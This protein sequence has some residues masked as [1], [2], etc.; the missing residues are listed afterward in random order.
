MSA[1]AA[2]PL[3]ELIDPVLWRAYA[4]TRS[5]AAR[6]KIVER[7]MEFVRIRACRLHERLPKEVDLQDLIQWGSEGLM[8]AVEAYDA[9]RGVVFKTY[10]GRRVLG[11]MLDGL[12][13]SARHSRV[14]MD[15]NKK[16]SA[17]EDVLYGT[18]G[19]WPVAAEVAAHLRITD[20]QHEMMVRSRAKTHLSLSRV[21]LEGNS[22][23]VEEIDL[24]V[25]SRMPNPTVALAITDEIENVFRVLL[26][27]DFHL[28][29]ALMVKCYYMLG[30]SM[31][32]IGEV[33]GLC[34]ARI[35]QMHR[36]IMPLLRAKLTKAA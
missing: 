28:R 15:R 5:A 19:V 12:R 25:D 32:E 26:S 13:E 21:R 30:M 6:N 8:Q 35:S 27:G 1:A 2:K 10:A 3:H 33:L 22:R 11:A 20:K 34:E 14:A 18:T 7:Y 9:A 36:E 4:R 31:R 24:L 17:A 23:D 16:L 29:D